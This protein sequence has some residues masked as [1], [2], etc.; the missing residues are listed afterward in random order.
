MLEAKV[1]NNATRAITQFFFGDLYFRY[2]DRVRAGSMF[3]SCRGSAIQNFKQRRILPP[4]AAHP[5]AWLA[6]RFDELDE[7]VATRKLIAQPLPPSRC[8]IWS[9]AASPIFTSTP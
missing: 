1:D 9:I 2:L 5:A 6:E 8:S 7:D 3:R 4:A